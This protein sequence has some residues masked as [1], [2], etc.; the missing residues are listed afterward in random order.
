MHHHKFLFVGAPGA[1]KTTA[2]A[3]V[4]D[5]APLC[6]DV[7]SSE[8]DRQTTVALDFGETRLGEDLRLGL[9]GVPGQ[10]RFDFLWPVL[11][12]GTLGVLLLLDARDAPGSERVQWLL[13]RCREHL[14]HAEL[15][16]G[17]THSD[18]PGAHPTAL[19]IPPLAACGID[20]PVLAVDTREPAQVQSLLRVLVAR[21]ES[22]VL[23][24]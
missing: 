6:T 24:S 14:S 13:Q 7:P 23:L 3:A 11:A 19:F 4:S 10:Q 15:V 18:L 8:E 5:I 22:L 1:G 9:Y 17:I 16:V 12:P 20:A 21:I 2:I